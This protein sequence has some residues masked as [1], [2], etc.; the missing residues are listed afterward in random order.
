M[1]KNKRK[2][3]TIR[4]TAETKAKLKMHA[5]LLD[6]KQSD[7]IRMAINLRLEELDKKIGIAS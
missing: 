2:T 1:E 7:L 6:V 4:I 5:E 3:T